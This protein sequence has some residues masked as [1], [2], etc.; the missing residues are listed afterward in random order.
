MFKI[1]SSKPQ[2]GILTEAPVIQ[3]AS[4]KPVSVE[5]RDAHGNAISR[6]T[7]LNKK[8]SVIAGVEVTL[9]EITPGVWYDKRKVTIT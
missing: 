2:S 3:Q 9:I 6:G 7:V 5:V 8:V 1:K 4:T